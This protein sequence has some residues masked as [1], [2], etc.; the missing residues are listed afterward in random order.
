MK[1]VLKLLK[2]I[3]KDRAWCP[4]CK[5]FVDDGEKRYSRQDPYHTVCG[6]DTY[7]SYLLDNHKEMLK[8]AV[9]I[10]EEGLNRE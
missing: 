8:K 5:R 2:E 6:E 9:D 10:L 3:L 7:K 4:M 1:V